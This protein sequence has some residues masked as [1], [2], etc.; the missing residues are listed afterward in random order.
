MPNDWS[1]ELVEEAT[2]DDLDENA[3]RKARAEYKKK[4]PNLVSQVDD[5]NDVTFLKKARVIINGKITK[6]AL[7]LLGKDESGHKLLPTIAKIT[8]EVRDINGN[9]EGYEHIRQ[10]FILA[11]D[12]LLSLIK[13]RLIRQMPSDTPFPEKALKYDNWVI[14]E[15]LH[16][17]IAHQNYQKKERILVIE[18]PD[19]ILFENAGSFIP[20]SVERVIEQDAPQRYYRNIFLSDAMVELNLIDTVGSG[21]KKMFTTQRERFFPLPTYDLS[22]PEITRVKIH[23]KEINPNFTDILRSRKE[24]KLLEVITL[25]KVQ[26]GIEISKED[27][28]ILKKLNVIEGKR[29]NYRISGIGKP[30]VKTDQLYISYSKFKEKLTNFIKKYGKASREDIEN[31]FMPLLPDNL[32]ISKKKKKITNMLYKM[33]K[34][35]KLINNI[36][37]TTKF[38]VW[39]LVEDTKDRKTKDNHNVAN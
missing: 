39:V 18:Y 4:N 33:S 28:D 20:G 3:L 32:T 22:S 13:N 9:S 31:L 16:N 15:A 24:L 35:D 19:Y 17:C 2:I 26:K 6:V 36:A 23:G 25:D 1:S 21:I 7:I 10:P 8:W 12:K 5:W 29:P 30:T 27:A 37:N 11:A 38:P 34:N 14:R